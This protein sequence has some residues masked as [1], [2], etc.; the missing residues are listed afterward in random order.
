[1]PPLLHFPYAFRGIVYCCSVRCLCRAEEAEL[2][3]RFHADSPDVLDLNSLSEV[4]QI[5][6]LK[7]CP[8]PASGFPNNEQG[9]LSSYA[10]RG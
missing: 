8:N 6:N 9:K 2:Q 3:R 1:M 10:L 7:L 5:Q 4:Q